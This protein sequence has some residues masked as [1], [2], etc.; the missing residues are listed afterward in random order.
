MALRDL[1]P[2]IDNR[3]FDDLV[4]EV[5]SRIPRYTPEWTD[6]NDN[7]PGMA[8]LQVFAWLTEL[9]LYRL[10]QVPQLNRLK[11]LELLGVELAPA[12][13]S[14]T[15]ISFP[16][17]VTA[18][19]TSVIIPQ[20]TQV[21]AQ[22][23]DGG[24]PLVFETEQ[25]LVAVRARLAVIQ[26][27]DGADHRRVGG[28][29]QPFD[30]FGPRA[31]AGAQLLLGFED[32][33]PL[34]AIP[35]D[36]AVVTAAA[37]LSAAP[38]ACGLPEPSIRPSTAVAW[39]FFDGN[40]WRSLTVRKDE[41]RGLRR[42]GHLLLRMPEPGAMAPGTIGV[43]SDRRRWWLRARLVRAEDERRPRLASIDTNTVAAVQAETVRGEVLGGGNGRP[44][45]RFQ[46]ANTPVLAGTLRLEVDGQP[47]AEV[48]DFFASGRAD[49]HVVLNRT[50]GTI[51][52]GDGEHGAVVPGNLDNPGGNVVAAEYRF[53]GGTR[54]NLPAGSVSTLLTSIAGVDE[55]A[56]SNRLAAHDGREEESLQ[57]AEYR[58]VQSLKSKCRAVT[59]ADFEQLA[60]E[61]ATIRRA[62]ALP[63]R[64]PRFP[65]VIVPGTVTVVVVPDSD[66]P[67]PMPG[68]DTLAAVCAYLDQRRL[69][70]TEVFVVAP[71]Y[72]L[73]QVRAQVVVEDG[74][75][76]GQVQ[77]DA[78]EALLAY[79]H[80]LTGG[81][82]GSGWPFGENVNFSE[83]Y[84]RVFTV[85]GLRR[86]GRLTI[87]LDG[88]EAD[89]CT[90][91][92]IPEG[93]LVYST[94]HDI[95]AVYDAG[96]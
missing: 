57:A 32:A 84:Q 50:T 75:D 54:G 79:L 72:R 67:R 85:P 53:G 22:A 56:V 29:G 62:K 38:F 37:G 91:V 59:A 52:A 21:A 23:P 82:A 95:Q 81:R 41:T 14:R 46:L 77:E 87:S 36:L 20:R 43:S 40:E 35:L 31:S 64:H 66:N 45:Q 74:F 73:V 78:E 33:A 17:M 25:A 1:A 5:R 48:G 61:A 76:L 68:E 16:L 83:V 24:P 26:V 3:R 90:N 6:V 34:P 4:D 60:M 9:Q 89:P 55:N 30:P 39:E 94:A 70:T 8:I 65:G 80:P 12:E 11:F 10:G 86:I 2:S 71:T 96:E 19:R 69:L 18:P 51:R 27:F 58:A 47:W 49:P 44:N 13:P 15:E 63:L 28:Q 42:S 93:Q 88:E 92:T 7:E